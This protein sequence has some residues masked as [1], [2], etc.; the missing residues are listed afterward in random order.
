MKAS[1][2]VT[3]IN[4]CLKQSDLEKSPQN[5]SLY[6]TVHVLKL[7]ATILSC[8]AI[9]YWS[10]WNGNENTS[11][12]PHGKLSYVIVNS[13]LSSLARLN[14]DHRQTTLNPKHRLNWRRQ[15]ICWI[16]SWNFGIHPNFHNRT[17]NTRL[18]YEKNKPSKVSYVV[19]LTGHP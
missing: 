16:T 9:S 1:L 13:T 7:Q 10:S 6:C 2:S 19:P 15:Q 3:R 17:L 4:P 11:P 12:P 8:M 18:T 5:D 14:G